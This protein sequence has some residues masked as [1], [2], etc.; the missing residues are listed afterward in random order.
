MSFKKKPAVQPSQPSALLKSTHA[1]IPNEK[2]SLKVTKTILGAAVCAFIAMAFLPIPCLAEDADANETAGNVNLM[3]DL[4]LRWNAVWGEFD[5]NILN[6]KQTA[7]PNGFMVELERSWQVLPGFG[8][9]F[10]PSFETVF[11]DER[12]S[13][14]G[15]AGEIDLWHDVISLNSINAAVKYFYEFTDSSQVVSCKLENGFGLS[16]VNQN[17]EYSDYAQGNGSGATVNAGNLRTT[18]LY[19]YLD[20]GLE[21][22]IHVTSAV[23]VGVNFNYMPTWISFGSL[24]QVTLMRTGLALKARF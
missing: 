22:S 17:E 14:Q 6:T 11:A 2:S 19:P 24:S 21:L 7:S 9:S 23:S 8:V 18:G 20:L 5:Y 13:V 4:T 15:A 16:M 10:A 1:K 3:N 12:F